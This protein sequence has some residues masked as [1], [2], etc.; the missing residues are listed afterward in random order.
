MMTTQRTRKTNPFLI[1]EQVKRI[2]HS[3]GLSK[4]FNYSDYTYFKGKVKKSFN[5][6]QAIA[7]MFI[8]EYKQE[9]DYTE[10]QF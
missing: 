2:L 8:E 7:E 4:V 10:Y 3:R 5:S 1:S 6:A 9:S